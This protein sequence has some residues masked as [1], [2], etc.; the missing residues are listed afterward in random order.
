MRPPLT[1]RAG[2]PATGSAGIVTFSGLTTF[3]VEADDQLIVLFG[4][5]GLVLEANAVV[6][7]QLVGD[8]PVVLHEERRST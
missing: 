5:T 8:A 6:H 7:R 1:C 2:V 4:Q 3:A